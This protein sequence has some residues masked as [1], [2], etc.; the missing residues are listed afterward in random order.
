MV[1]RDLD[2]GGGKQWTVL[3]GGTIR[4]FS[5]LTK[6]GPKNCYFSPN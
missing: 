2:L 5:E 1:V 4:F 6:L 3:L